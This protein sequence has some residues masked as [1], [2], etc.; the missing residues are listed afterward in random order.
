MMSGKI[1]SGKGKA[2]KIL[3]M[4]TTHSCYA[5]AETL[6]EDH[7]HVL[8][9][10]CRIRNG[11]LNGVETIRLRKY[12][13]WFLERYLEPHFEIEEEHIFPIL[14][15]NARVKKALANHRR[16]KRLLSCSCEN[17][18]VLNLLEEELASHVRF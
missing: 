16:I 3:G 9:M 13:D 5:G 17:L 2:A 4:E 1:N 10:C 18:K 11:L 8:K 12:A 6:L 14:G 15:T 7:D